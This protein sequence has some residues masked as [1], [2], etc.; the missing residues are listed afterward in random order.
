[1][2]TK[3]KRLN[4]IT[5]VSLW[6]LLSSTYLPFQQSQFS[7]LSNSFAKAGWETALCF[8]GK[9][10][11]HIYLT[12]LRKNWAP[13]SHSMGTSSVPTNTPGNTKPSGKRWEFAILG[14]QHFSE[15]LLVGPRYLCEEFQQ[16]CQWDGPAGKALALQTWWPEF[17]PWNPGKIRFWKQTYIFLAL[18]EG[19]E[20]RKSPDSFPGHA[21][22]V[23]SAETDRSERACL[24]QGEWRKTKSQELFSDPN[25]EAMACKCPHSH[26][27]KNKGKLI[28]QTP[29]VKKYCSQAQ[30]GSGII[31]LYAVNISCS[32]WLIIRL[33]WPITRQ[34]S[35]RRESQTE[36]TGRKKGGEK[37]DASSCQRNKMY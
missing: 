3:R 33:I 4:L 32:H 27:N 14:R 37:R 11:H 19:E 28:W 6:V 29:T 5:E 34:N 7:L 24:K 16:R 23:C 1:M 2:P 21:D 8:E 10:T 12:N 31:L 30:T 26:A 20:A 36:N 17:S 25:R 35:A 22:R 9:K 15:M 18:L 13:T